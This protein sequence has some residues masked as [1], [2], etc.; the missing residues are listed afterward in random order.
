MLQIPFVFGREKA[1]RLRSFTDF[2]VAISVGSHPFPSRTRKLSPPEPMVLHG[3]PC[4]RVGR[5]RIFSRPL[6]LSRAGGFFFGGAE[7]DALGVGALRYTPRFRTAGA[8]R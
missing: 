2:A 6:A 7:G 4:G 8:V 3:K 5:C 1:S